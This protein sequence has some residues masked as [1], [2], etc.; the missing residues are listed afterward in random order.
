MHRLVRSF[1]MNLV[2]MLY[3]SCALFL[4]FDGTLV[5]IAPQPEAVV[6]PPRLVA[7]LGSLNNYLGGAL[8]LISGRPIAQI[9]EFLQPLRLP[10]AGVHR[11]Q[12]R[13]ADGDI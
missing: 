9:D 6:V 1:T 12:R 11:G 13:A 10:A 7:T 5:D 8:A 4:D 2:D 3:P